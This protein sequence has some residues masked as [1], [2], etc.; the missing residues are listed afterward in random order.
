MVSHLCLFVFAVFGL[1]SIIADKLKCKTS[2]DSRTA[3]LDCH[4][5]CKDVKIRFLKWT[6]N[7]SALALYN[8]S[9]YTR[10]NRIGFRQ[11]WNNS[12]QDISL[13]INDITKE[14]SGEYNYSVISDCDTLTGSVHL[15]IPDLTTT[16]PVQ[17]EPNNEFKT[18]AETNPL[19]QE[20]TEKP[21]HSPVLPVVV[22]LTAVLVLG[23]LVLWK[24]KNIPFSCT[25]SEKGQS[26]GNLPVENYPVANCTERTAEEGL[27]HTN[28]GTDSYD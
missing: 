20:E 2:V 19:K 18:K 26:K 24:R 16:S 22:I 9:S 4:L 5:L 14:D 27:L 6:K 25:T 8:G 11:P 21:R 1:R 13:Q 3:V 17:K 15:E 12:S 23:I 28:K 10:T 7:Q